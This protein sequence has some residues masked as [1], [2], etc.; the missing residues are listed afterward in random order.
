MISIVTTAHNEEGNVIPLHKSLN[1]ALGD[2]DYELI[3]VNDGS[4]DNTAN[5]LMKIAN[6][7][8][9]ILNLK[10]HSGQSFA[11]HSGLR[12]AAGDIIVTMDADLQN[13][14]RDIPGMLKKLESGYDCV[15]GWRH[16]RKDNLFKR[17]F[18]RLGNMLY[19][20][21]FGMGF[22]DNNCTLKVFR[23]EC[24]SG[25]RY[26][27]G[28]HRFLPALMKFQGLSM[29]EYRISHRPRLFG[30]SKYGILDRIPIN[31]KTLLKI[32]FSHRMFLL[33]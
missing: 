16:R 31:L 29:R 3:W 13:D 6:E 2:M 23:R 18:S 10:R 24:V 28:Y 15:I 27:E 14:P 12:L 17:M 5:E 9:K 4:T 8:V 32:R 11:L 25:I 26:F 22:H 21:A 20:A 30:A 33:S 7:G 19:N 1:K